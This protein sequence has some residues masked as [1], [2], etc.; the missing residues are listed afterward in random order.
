DLVIALGGD[1]TLLRVSRLFPRDVPP[2]VGVSMGTLGFLMPIHQNEVVPLLRRVLD[3]T[4][5][6][7]AHAASSAAA[8]VSPSPPSPLSS[9]SVPVLIRSRLTCTLFDADGQRLPFPA[10]DAAQP[11]SAVGDAYALNDITLHRGPHPH[12]ST[13]TCHIDRA[14]LTTVTADGLVVSTPTG[15]TAY[16]LSAGGPI[17]D[18]RVPC[19]GLTPIC[20]RSLSFRPVLVP[21]DAAI[22]LGV[23]RWSRGQP[24]VAVDGLR[25][26][27]L[28]RG[29][30]L[31]IEASACGIPVV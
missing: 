25:I 27:P 29:Q 7:D 5:S 31:V 6:S 19:L 4:G 24:E 28:R 8:H 15:S 21:A 17:I 14:P 18:P 10:A 2:V 11:G 20:P 26:G 9:P 13:I 30:R 16:A 23:A 22:T 1:G 12:L 3:G